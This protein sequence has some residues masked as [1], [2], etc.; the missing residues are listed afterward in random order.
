MGSHYTLP[1]SVWNTGIFWRNDKL[2]IDPA[3]M[4]NPYDVFWD[5]APK[6]KTALLANAQDVLAMP[7]FRDGLTDVNVTDPTVITKAKDDI[8]QIATEGGRAPYDHV[9]YNDVPAGKTLAA[10]V[11]V[12]QRQ[13]R[14][15]LPAPNKSDA[16]NL[17]YYWPGSDG[18]SRPTSTTTRSSC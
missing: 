2:N 3:T 1:Y 7:M 14:R 10:P 11:V 12:G 4:S 15:R 6:G 9:D 13:R 17:S 5:N 8:T 18:S 16:D